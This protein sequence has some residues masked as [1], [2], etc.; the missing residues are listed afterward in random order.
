MVHAGLLGVRT[1]GLRRWGW[2]SP[3]RLCMRRHLREDSPNTCSCN[4]TGCLRWDVASEV[5]DQLGLLRQLALWRRLVQLWIVK[6][7]E[8]IL[9]KQEQLLR[10]R[11]VRH[12]LL[13]VC[14]F[15][16]A[17]RSGF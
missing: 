7:I 12:Q 3:A 9:C 16:L 4:A 17:K 6:L 2:C 1:K 13:V 14:I 10:C 15:R 5:I 8:A 11:V